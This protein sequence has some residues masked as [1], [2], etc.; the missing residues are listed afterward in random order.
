[1]EDRCSHPHLLF[2]YIPLHQQMNSSIDQKWS[3]EGKQ[4]C[5]RVRWR[6]GVFIL[7]HTY[8]MTCI[9]MPDVSKCNAKHMITA[10]ESL[11]R[12]EYCTIRSKQRTCV[13]RYVWFSLQF[14]DNVLRLGHLQ[15]SH[16]LYEY[17]FFLFSDSSLVSDV[18]QWPPVWIQSK[19]IWFIVILLSHFNH[20]WL[21]YNRLWN[22]ETHYRRFRTRGTFF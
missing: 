5:R 10:T 14:S 8:S 12:T 4:T 18:Q 22:Y 13:L 7:Y 2:H 9:F 11:L 1:M 3:A 21:H 15:L 17:I 16:V 20:L 19:H 6:G